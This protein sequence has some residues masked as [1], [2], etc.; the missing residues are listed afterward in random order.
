MSPRF[1]QAKATFATFNLPTVP[2]KYDKLYKAKHYAEPERVH[3]VNLFRLSCTCADYETRR[4]RFPPNDVRLVCK[5]LL[6]KL[7]YVKLYQTYDSLTANLLHCSAYFG[8]DDFLR[9]EI[10]GMP[11]VLSSSDHSHWVNVH[12]ASIPKS[13]TAVVRFAFDVQ[14]RTWQYE[15]PARASEIEK[16]IVSIL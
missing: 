16:Y 9:C 5:H 3:S 8:D 7:K 2:D 12:F 4:T 13:P 15:R 11:Y 6:D 10:G 14:E 1:Q